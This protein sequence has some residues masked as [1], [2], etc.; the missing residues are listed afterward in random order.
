VVCGGVCVFVCV[1]ICVYVLFFGLGLGNSTSPISCVLCVCV[2][3]M[4]F[5][6]CQ[7]TVCCV[8]ACVYLCVCAHGICFFVPIVLEFRRDS[9]VCRIGLFFHCKMGLF[10]HCKIGFFSCRYW[11]FDEPS[12]VVKVRQAQSI[13]SF[14]CRA[15]LNVGL[16]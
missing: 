1:C 8:C 14:D 3:V 5:P 12:K 9:F 13:G 15:L 16:F 10:F 4:Q 7:Y 11:N 2:C 6:S